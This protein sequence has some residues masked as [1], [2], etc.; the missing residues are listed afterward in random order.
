MRDLATIPQ[1]TTDPWPVHQK[2]T[3]PINHYKRKSIYV[4]MGYIGKTDRA[5]G[6]QRK[7]TAV[8]ASDVKDSVKTSKLLTAV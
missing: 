3:S 7:E 2:E 5:Q 6:Q 8:V 4:Y 1:R